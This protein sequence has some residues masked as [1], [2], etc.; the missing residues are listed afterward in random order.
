[1]TTSGFWQQ[2]QADG[3]RVP[4]QR[5]LDDLTAE[6]T[7]MLGSPD[8]ETRD[9]LAYPALA[10]WIHRGVYDDLLR[11]LG[12]GIATGLLTGLGESGTDSVFRR[13]W[14]ALVLG[15]CLARDNEVLRLEAATV[16]RWGDHLATWLLREQD[17]RGYVP[18]QGWAHAI[19]HGADAL[20]QLARSR[21]LEQPELTAILDVVADRVTVPGARLNS[22][23]PD[24]LATTVMALL[25]R[26]LLPLSLLE[27]WVNRLRLAA[28]ARVA[29]DRDPY[30]AT[31]NAE[32]FLRALHLQVVLSP[33]APSLRADLL[34]VLV[35]ALRASNA[36]HLIGY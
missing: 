20:S 32:A 11:G 13:S 10:T 6:L 36:R 15:E 2:V 14:S 1:M 17:L 16:L 21:H 8:P 33:Q 27:P 19:A 4:A 28:T 34:L 5:P 3:L 29:G 18:G 31:G 23:E 9:G 35:D 12:D 7:A 24:R 30:D 26:D 25:G 22:G